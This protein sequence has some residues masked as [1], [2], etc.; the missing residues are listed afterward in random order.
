MHLFKW[1]IN[2]CRPLQNKKPLLYTIVNSNLAQQLISANAILLTMMI[3][4]I[5]IPPHLSLHDCRVVAQFPTV[6][7]VVACAD[8]AEGAVGNLL[9]SK[10]LKKRERKT[11]KTFEPNDIKLRLVSPFF[12]RLFN[13]L[14]TF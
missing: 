2:I 6:V 8:G 3:S 9:E 5:L 1:N 7:V 13:N 4:N 11:L 12:R 14:N 10:H